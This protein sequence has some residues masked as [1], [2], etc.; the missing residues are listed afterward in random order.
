MKEGNMV[1]RILVLLVALL[2]VTPL[3]AEG[4]KEGGGEKQKVYTM[5]F[6]HGLPPT[7]PWAKTLGEFARLVEQKSDGQIKVKVYPSGQLYK[8]NKLY[9]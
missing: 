3:F 4:N 1:K 9:V 6:S 2:V 7:H 5:R 8:P